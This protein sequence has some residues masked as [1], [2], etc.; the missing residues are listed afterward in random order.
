MLNII[1]E[2]GRRKAGG[3]RPMSWSLHMHTGA[4]YGYITFISSSEQGTRR[5]ANIPLW[6]RRF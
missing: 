5:L 3:A 6:L 2:K 1:R 4:L